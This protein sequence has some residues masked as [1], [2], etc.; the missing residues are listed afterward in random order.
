MERKIID[1]KAISCG[2]LEDY[3]IFERQSAPYDGLNTQA[4]TLIGKGYEPYGEIKITYSP[5]YQIPG[6]MSTGGGQVNYY[7]EFVKYES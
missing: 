5:V 3:T 7:R 4:N 1:F 2:H 6:L